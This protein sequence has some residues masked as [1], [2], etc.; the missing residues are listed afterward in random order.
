MG[1]SP[2]WTKRDMA[3]LYYFMLCYR[4][5]ILR[6]RNDI[7]HMEIRKAQYNSGDDSGTRLG[8]SVLRRPRLYSCAAPDISRF[9]CAVL[10]D[11]LRNLEFCHGEVPGHFP[12]LVPIWSHLRRLQLHARTSLADVQA[13]TCNFGRAVLF[14]FFLL[15]FSRPAS[16]IRRCSV[17][18]E[19]E[20]CTLHEDVGTDT[21]IGDVSAGVNMGGYPE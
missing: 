3:A 5:S 1:C 15:L 6:S 2:T 14:S 17:Q 21:V 7:L 16:D 10:R 20:P 4:A 19:R 8:L 11:D 12:L 18:S 9:M 13:R